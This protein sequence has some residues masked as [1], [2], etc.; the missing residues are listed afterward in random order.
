VIEQPWMDGWM[1]GRTKSCGPAQEH[2]VG[3]EA[4]DSVEDTDSPPHATAL[5]AGYSQPAAH[6]LP[7]ATF[8]RCVRST[9]VPRSPG[10]QKEYVEKPLNVLFLHV[11]YSHIEH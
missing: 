7:L 11:T 3:D 2:T 6:S 5:T 10:Q 8:S 4:T 1:D 9:C